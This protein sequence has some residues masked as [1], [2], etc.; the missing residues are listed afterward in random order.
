MAKTPDT[1]DPHAKEKAAVTKLATSLNRTQN[2]LNTINAV[3][4]FV[5]SHPIIITL[6]IIGGII[7]AAIVVNKI[8][9]IP[10]PDNSVHSTPINDP[11]ESLETE[12][13]P[14]L[15]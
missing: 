9:K 3:R 11:Y 4:T 14:E 7:S 6:T 5:K 15:P 10:K 12:T 8:S 1:P 2:T 13:Y